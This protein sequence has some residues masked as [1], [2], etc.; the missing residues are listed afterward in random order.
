MPWTNYRW[1]HSAWHDLGARSSWGLTPE[2]HV[3]IVDRNQYSLDGVITDT[4]SYSKSSSLPGIPM[5]LGAINRNGFSIN[6]I[7]LD[8]AYCKIWNGPT[9]VFDGT[10]AERN[11]VAGLFDS[12]S[13]SLFSS[14]NTSYPYTLQS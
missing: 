13:N 10:A 1:G 8:I 2:W 14:R 4:S 3:I 5:Y 11:G 9:L 7:P 6:C 12:V